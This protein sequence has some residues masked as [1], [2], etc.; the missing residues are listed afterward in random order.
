[1][2]KYSGLNL[3]DPPGTRNAETSLCDQELARYSKEVTKDG[4]LEEEKFGGI[5]K[6]GP[7]CLCET[8]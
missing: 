3:D 7:K 4:K 1:M 5:T 2:R 8:R 6:R